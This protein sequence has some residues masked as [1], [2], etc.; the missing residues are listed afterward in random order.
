ME[1]PR[2]AV[3][4]C[5]ATLLSV[6]FVIT[7]G[8]CYN[9]LL[10]AKGNKDEHHHKEV[11][12]HKDEHH[13]KNSVM[14]EMHVTLYDFELLGLDGEMINLAE[15]KGKVVLVVNTAARCNLAASQFSELEELSERYKDQGL[16][17]IGVSSNDFG[18]EAEDLE[19]RMCI[20][21]EHVQ[22]TFLM[23]DTVHVTDK[24]GSYEAIPLYKW[25]NEEG[26]KKNR[27]FGSVK[28]S[29]HKFLIGKDGMVIDYFAATTKPLSKKI[30][31][32]I[33]NAF[34]R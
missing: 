15:L 22:P 27:V 14:Q 5:A 13:G 18:Q 1:N 6:A 2:F 19:K 33:E 26:A 20:I 29:F 8:I 28:W 17:V 7:V 12:S 4:I 30:A 10:K 32:A 34:T 25:L 23:T 16:V 24:K 31:E 9:P 3:S 11:H 21:K